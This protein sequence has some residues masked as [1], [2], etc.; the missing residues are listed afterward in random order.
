MSRTVTHNNVQWTGVPA[1]WLGVVGSYGGTNNGWST[2]YPA[3]NC[4]TNSS[5]STYGQIVPP[6]NTA[7]YNCTQRFGFSI[8]GIPSNATINS[9]T[10]TIKI[11]CSN[12]SGFQI[13]TAQFYAGDTAKGTAL[14]FTNNSSTTARSYTTCGSWTRAELDSL[15]LKII[16]KKSGTSNRY[17]NFYGADLTI[18]YSYDETEYE[19]SSSSNSS[20]ITV[21]PAS[22]YIVEGSSG[23]ITFSNI[24]DITEV[25]VSDN[26]IGV[27]AQLVN[28]SGT[29]Y[30][31]TIENISADHT[32][33]V[34]DVPSVYLTVVNNSTYV[35]NVVPTSGSST[36]LAQ[37]TNYGIKI[38][39]NDIENVDIFDDGVKNNN[40][41]LEY[42][43]EDTSI[44][45]IPS[46]YS[47]N[48]FNGSSSMNYINGYTNSSSTT[49][50][51]L[52]IGTKNADQSIFYK[53]DVSSIPADATVISVSNCK[54]KIC[55]SASLSSTNTGVQLYSGNTSKS[56]KNYSG[57]YTNTSAN[58]YTLSG[59]GTFT[60]EELNDL[61]L[62]ITGRTS[63]ANRSIYF[64]GA[65]ITIEYEYLGAVYYLYTST[66]DKTKTV[67]LADHSSNT[68]FI[69]QNSTWA[70][71]SHVYQ[72]ENGSWVEI[73]DPAS[74]LNTNKIYIL[75]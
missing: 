26:G 34:N 11:A 55:V 51:V 41:T 30:T 16:S 28:T 53:F 6:S 9:V 70:P 69:K 19:I 49:R 64:Y 48:T 18:T 74:I 57:W 44:E 52:Q 62:K 36:K 46:T 61:K 17:V 33:V 42:D 13:A 8:S 24:S 27:S 68:V 29:T 45:C 5:S 37:G 60:R 23:T 50:A 39:T 71:I 73:S 31:Y 38:F 59:L 12:A 10:C 14:D 7:T 65:D 43:I 1:V 4:L 22:Q 72:K 56:N 35:T 40:T 15:E 25:G 3:T 75:K 47:D 58:V 20:T 2:S 63:T 21:S 54:F 32:I 67:R 66:V